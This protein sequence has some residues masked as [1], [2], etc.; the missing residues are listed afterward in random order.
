MFFCGHI[1]LC[2]VTLSPIII[3][4]VL[5]LTPYPYPSGNFEPNNYVAKKYFFGDKTIVKMALQSIENKVL[6]IINRKKHGAILFASDFTDIGER[7]AINKAFEAS[8]YQARLSG[9]QGG[10]IS[11][12]GTLA[13]RQYLRHLAT[14][15]CRRLF[16]ETEG[17]LLTFSEFRLRH[18]SDI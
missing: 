18:I 16:D 12:N 2:V 11:F 9:L 5:F 3:K 10:K 13:H 7:K 15:Y 4:T 14:A 6:S 17:F 1:L 8:P